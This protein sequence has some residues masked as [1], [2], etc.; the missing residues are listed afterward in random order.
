MMSFAVRVLSM[1]ALSV[2]ALRCSSSRLPL[3]RIEPEMD[4]EESEVVRGR[5]G[6]H[7]VSRLAT[8]T[9][10]LLHPGGALHNRRGR[11]IA[12]ALGGLDLLEG[13]WLQRG[14]LDGRAG[15]VRRS[16]LDAIDAAIAEGTI[17]SQWPPGGGSQAIPIP[18]ATE[19]A[20]RY[21]VLRSAA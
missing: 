1:P 18:M 11:R 4:H 5:V 7:S 10:V 21:G 17:P 19:A 13:W 14:W 20:Y 16:M 2:Y 8:R 9:W 6:L 15:H 3:D 12:V